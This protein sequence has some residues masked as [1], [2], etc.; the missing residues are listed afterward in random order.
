MVAAKRSIAAYA[1]YI[2]KVAVYYIAHHFLSHVV[3]G[4]ENGVHRYLAVLAPFLMPIV[5]PYLR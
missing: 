5:E 1:F 4:P 3:F 2:E